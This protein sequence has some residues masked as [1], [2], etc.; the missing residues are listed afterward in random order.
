[1]DIPIE[2]YKR[3]DILGVPLDTLDMQSA[4]GASENFMQNRKI[5]ACI[6]AVNPEKIIVLQR[7]QW[8]LDFFLKADLLLPDGI[9]AVWAARTLYGSSV[10]RVPGAD[11]MKHLCRIAAKKGYRIFFYG[12][13]EEVSDLAA[14]QLKDRYHG[15]KVVGRRNGY[16]SSDEMPDLISEINQ[17]GADILFVALG[18]PRQEQWIAQYRNVLQVKVIQGIGGT[19]DTITGHVKRAPIIWQKA[20]L[21]WFYR[22]MNQPARINRQMVYPLFVGQV[23]W[24]K[25]FGKRF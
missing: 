5:P 6:L 15:L 24:K 23:I 21:E 16:M 14:K 25:I 17:S 13:R 4:L 7:D 9:G 8:L 11:F 22:L 2:K 10:E 18:S 1:M 12:A 3:I 19:L 20:N